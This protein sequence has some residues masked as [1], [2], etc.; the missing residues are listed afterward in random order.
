MVIMAVT[1]R[2]LAR[3]DFAQFVA[4]VS[5]GAFLGQIGCVGTQRTVL[6]NL[7][8]GNRDDPLQFAS[9]V[10]NASIDISTA[11]FVFLPATAL[12]GSFGLS[13]L[14]G[15]GARPTDMAATALI[16]W[17]SG[18]QQLTAATLR[19]LRRTRM[20]GLLEGRS[21]GGLVAI[22]QAAGLFAALLAAGGFGLDA[23]LWLV[24]LGYFVPV[25][26]GTVYANRIWKKQG[27]QIS[28]KL[29]PSVLKK[30]FPMAA[31]T[32]L[33]QANGNLDVWIASL[34]LSGDQGAYFAAAARLA[35]LVN[36][37]LTSVQTIISPM[38]ARLYARGERTILTRVCRTASTVSLAGSS[39]L[40]VPMLAV[41]GSLLSIAYGTDYKT[42]SIPLVILALGAAANVAAG[43][44]GALMTM[45]GRE[46]QLAILMAIAV[47][48]RLTI[49]VAVVPLDSSIVLA[50][51]SAAV[52]T[53]LFISIAT[54]AYK[55]LG[56]RTWPT[57][58]PEVKLVAK[59][60][61]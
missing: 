41:P 36:I 30:N 28:V 24:A 7:A 39:F 53:L 54:V 50:L 17:L 34:A 40:W 9:D 55:G 16:V 35:F 56:I 11:V 45:S 58:H 15:Q 14:I 25:A 12:L 26:F 48:A 31:S 49:A 3:G 6:R 47:C 22:T 43:P 18:V 20:A 42:A 44:C 46:K 19:G 2:A 1:A 5:I 13:F 52:T 32:G 57:L 33:I 38:L 4:S 8:S 23:A 21:G 51:T 10:R 59:M 61:A 29:A 60:S 37:P 27:L